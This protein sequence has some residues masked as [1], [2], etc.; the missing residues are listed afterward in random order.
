[1]E[2]FY[3]TLKLGKGGASLGLTST[4]GIKYMDYQHNS[5]MFKNCYVTEY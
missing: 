4:S 2:L 5:W 3:R 1:M